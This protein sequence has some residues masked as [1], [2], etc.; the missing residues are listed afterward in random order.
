METRIALINLIERFPNL[1]LAVAP[2]ELN[3]LPVPL[4]NRLD[5]LPVV[6]G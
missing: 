1:K 4:L 2:D 5:G 3:L 6:L